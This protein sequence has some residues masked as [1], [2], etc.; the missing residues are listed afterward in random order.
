MG[1]GT[2]DPLAGKSQALKAALAAVERMN[3]AAVRRDPKVKDLAAK[4]AAK[5]GRR[6]RRAESHETGET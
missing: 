5:P 6:A 3:G 2:K 1:K 4:N